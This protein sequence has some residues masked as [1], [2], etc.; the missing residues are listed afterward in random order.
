MASQLPLPYIPRELEGEVVTQRQRDGYINATAMC[1]AAGKQFNDYARLGSTR[2]FVTELSAETGIP[3]TELIQ[4][5]RGGIPTEQG[6]WVHPQVAIHLAQWL[7]ARFAVRVTA[8]VYEWLSTDHFRRAGSLPYHLRRYVTNARNVPTGH[9]S[10]LTEI[11]MALIAP[12]EM[13]GYVLP[14]RLWPDISQGRM[15]AKWLRETK[16][17]DTDALPTYTHVFEDGR[18]SVQAKAYPNEWLADF[19]RHFLEVWMPQRALDY[20][21]ERDATALEYLPRLLPA[22]EREDPVL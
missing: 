12:L 5:V 6:T 10:V 15:F 9:F 18:P 20:F 17:V 2:P 16:G 13:I 19:R 4:S 14:E 3:V 22:P 8:W 1:Q 11:T 7:S 21:R